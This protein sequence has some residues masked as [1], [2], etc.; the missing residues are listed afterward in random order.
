METLKEYEMRASVLLNSDVCRFYPQIVQAAKERDWVW[1]A[2]GKNNS[3]LQTDVRAH[4]ERR[5]LTEVV[6]AIKE[7]TGHQPKGWL[8]PVLTETLNTPDILAELGITYICDWCNDDQPYP[9]KVK[10]GR[11]ISIPYS[12]EINDIEAFVSRGLTGQEYL[13][14]VIDQF[15]VLYD[16]GTK[17]GKVMCLPIHPFVL[18]QPFRHKY[19]ERALDYITS[20]KKVWITTSDEIADWYYEQYYSIAVNSKGLKKEES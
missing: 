15:D 13:Q 4:Q 14:Q 5:Y 1:L 7:S 10:H 9:C 17:S 19:L 6:T 2:H 16:E 3:T 12:V 20:H 11:M 18:N 8:G